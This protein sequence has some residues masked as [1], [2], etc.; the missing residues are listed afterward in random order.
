MKILI[1][2]MHCIENEFNLCIESIKN[3]TYRDFTYF[4]VENLKNKEAHDRLYRTFMDNADS[5]DIFIKIDADMVLCEDTFFE[6]V[7][8]R[9][10]EDSQLD[11]LEIA[12]HD[13]F[14]DRLVYGMHVYS[15]RTK[16]LK[17]NEDIFVDMVLPKSFCHKYDNGD[18]EPAAIHSPDPSL[19]Q[20]YHF[21]IHKAVKFMQNN[22]KNFLEI[23]SKVHWENITII[24]KN[25]RSKQ[26]TRLAAA[27][28]GAMDAIKHKYTSAHVD[29]NNPA[30]LSRFKEYSPQKLLPLARKVAGIFAFI[31]NGWLYRY[32]LAGRK[33]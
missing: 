19:F 25:F 21:G 12:V 5:Y 18:L 27:L 22:Q 23:P 4:V 3:Q 10:K 2:I 28:V 24:A 15:S 20:S 6:K 9:F 1:G 32:Y 33:A 16:W 26:D 11:D 13:F 8:D 7:I 29:Y 14:T 30:I 31:P 17:N